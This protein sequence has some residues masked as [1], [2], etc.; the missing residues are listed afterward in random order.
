MKISRSSIGALLISIVA[1]GL[2]ANTA[3][4]RG[5]NPTAVVG[6][7]DSRAVAVA[8]VRSELFDS[9]LKELR[10]RLAL[11]KTTRDQATIKR[12]KEMVPTIQELAQKQAFAA[13]PV[14]N[15][16]DLIRDK[17]PMVAEKA[18]VDVIVSKWVVAY[19]AKDAKFVDVT[20]QMTDVFVPDAETKKIIAELITT[21]P[22]RL[23]PDGKAK[24]PAKKNPTKGGRK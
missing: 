11:A 7:F 5:A 6:V 9:R 15:I 3:T 1:L 4:T 21:K 20:Q 13:E 10:Q 24:A 14:D 16:I 17:L 8:F 19:Y 22:I 12:L 23:G 2:G 18:G